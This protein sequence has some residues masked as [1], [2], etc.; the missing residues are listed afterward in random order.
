MRDPEKVS[1]L[2]ALLDEHA[3]SART[4]LYPAVVQSAITIDKT[5]VERFEDGDDYIYWPN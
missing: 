4:P 1:K 3:A 2:M 5:S